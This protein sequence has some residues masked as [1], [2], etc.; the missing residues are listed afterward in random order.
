PGGSSGAGSA[1]SALASTGLEV[2]ITELD[3]SGSSAND[4][5]TVL[6]AC[7]DTPSCVSITSWCVSD[8]NSWRSDSRPCLFDSNYQPKPAYTA[9]ISALSALPAK[10]TTSANPTSTSTTSASLI[11]AATTPGRAIANPPT[12]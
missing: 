9:I 8:I 12:L 1:L 11:I 5:L 6:H 7:L 3:I 2:A 4:Y 10:T